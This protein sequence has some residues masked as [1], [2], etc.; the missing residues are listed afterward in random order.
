MD[1]SNEFQFMLDRAIESEPLAFKVFDR[2]KNVQDQL[3][4]M[5]KGKQ[6]SWQLSQSFWNYLWTKE[7]EVISE[8]MEQFWLA[9]VMKERFGKIRSGEDWIKINI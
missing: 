9:F 6:T 1:N 8:S 7:E 3:Q 5:A 2:T 4:E